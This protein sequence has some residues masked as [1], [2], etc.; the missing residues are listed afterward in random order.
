VGAELKGENTIRGRYRAAIKKGGLTKRKKIKVG[1]DVVCRGS[2]KKKKR[3][4]PD[5]LG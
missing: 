2:G 5:L 3:K 4:E 1:G